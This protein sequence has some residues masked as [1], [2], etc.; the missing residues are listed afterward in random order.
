MSRRKYT[1]SSGELRPTWTPH[2]SVQS[3]HLQLDFRLRLMTSEFTRAESNVSP[4]QTAGKEEKHKKKIFF[5]LP[6]DWSSERKFPVYFMGETVNME[7]SVDHPNPSLRLY[8]GS[9]VAT[10]TPDVTSHPRYPFIDHRG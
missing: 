5:A 10:L 9:C 3:T 1:V 6:G 2:I 8:V 7:A 4:Q